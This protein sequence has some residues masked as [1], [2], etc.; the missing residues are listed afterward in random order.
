MGQFIPSVAFKTIDERTARPRNSCRKCFGIILGKPHNGKKICYDCY[1][2]NKRELSKKSKAKQRRM[3]G[4]KKN[5]ECKDMATAMR[6]I[7]S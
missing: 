1:A 5:P 4:I 3:A 7:K 2:Q 6:S